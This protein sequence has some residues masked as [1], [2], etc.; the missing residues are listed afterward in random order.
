MT[1]KD[2]VYYEEGKLLRLTTVN[3]RYLKGSEVGHKNTNGYIIVWDGAVRHRAHRLIWEMFFG[4]IPDGLEIDHIN[5]NRSDNRIENLRLVNRSE[6][7]LN[8]GIRVDN[9]SGYKGVSFDKKRSKYLVQANSKFVCYSDC[10][11][12]GYQRYLEAIEKE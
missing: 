7:N 12:E 8:T 11:K 4:E 6:N 5:R 10:P 9:T 1:I 3:K 2:R